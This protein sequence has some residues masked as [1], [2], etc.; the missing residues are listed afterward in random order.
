MEY[1]LIYCWLL[2]FEWVKQNW[3]WVLLGI[4]AAL[5]LL[6]IVRDAKK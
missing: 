4:G 6:N 1:A 2:L 3:M 5:L